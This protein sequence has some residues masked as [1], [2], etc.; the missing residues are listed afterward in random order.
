M[1][2]PQ[3]RDGVVVLQIGHGRANAMDL[4]LLQGLAREIDRLPVETTKAVVLTGTGEMFSAGIDLPMLLE[5]GPDYTFELIDALNGL[6]EKFI[7]LS[8]PSVAA[9][10]GHAIAGGFVLASAC[11]VR[12]MTSGRGKVG[13][14][15]LLV[16]V[17]FPPL[18]L[19]VVRSAVGDRSA[20]RMV[21]F[22][23][24]FDAAAAETLG[25]VDEL[26]GPTTL[27][28]RAA[29]IGERLGRV[30]AAAFRLTKRQLMAPLRMR[31]ARLGDRQEREARQTWVSPETRE[32]MADFIRD[33]L[34]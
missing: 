26:V 14:T 5:G 10:N 29:E 22:G 33:R 3:D 6:L 2:S 27:L 28:D 21:L 32:V 19:E 7:E 31:L 23:E 4:A 1:I 25:L 15:E 34:G 9:I 24:L 12:L 8:I 17:P 20:R 30:P 13:L 16:G 18:A 11:D